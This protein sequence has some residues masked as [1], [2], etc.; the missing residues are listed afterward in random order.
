[1]VF[2]LTCDIL[3]LILKGKSTALFDLDSVYDRLSLESKK[4]RTI[5]Y[6]IRIDFIIHWTQID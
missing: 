6:E 5:F 2:A 4:P 3:C 1:M